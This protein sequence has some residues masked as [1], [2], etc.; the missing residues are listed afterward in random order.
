MVGVCHAF[1]NG[2]ARE[3]PVIATYDGSRFSHRPHRVSHWDPPPILPSVGL[4][5]THDGWGNI[6]LSSVSW[7]GGGAGCVHGPGSSTMRHAGVP[8]PNAIKRY[9]AL[10]RF[11]E[12]SVHWYDYAV[13]ASYSYS[14]GSLNEPAAIPGA[15]LGIDPRHFT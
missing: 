11:H 15:D 12:N 1:S 7:R 9:S 6:S 14:D 5:A 13:T 3:E 10:R 4:S 2:L 8:S